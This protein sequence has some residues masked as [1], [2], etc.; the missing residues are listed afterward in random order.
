MEDK[1][2]VIWTIA[3]YLRKHLESAEGP[4][5]ETWLFALRTKVRGCAKCKPKRGKSFCPG[6]NIMLV[7]CLLFNMV[8]LGCGAGFCFYALYSP[9]VPTWA[10]AAPIILFGVTVVITATGFR[11]L[12]GQGQ[13]GASLLTMLPTSSDFAAAPKKISPVPASELYA[14]H[15]RTAVGGGVDSVG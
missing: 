15:D 12:G 2:W 4:S 9:A 7:E 11:R 14:Q 13:G 6:R 5:W 8:S 1:R 3:A 10:F